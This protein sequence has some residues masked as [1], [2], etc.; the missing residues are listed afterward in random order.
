MP[1]TPPEPS[2]YGMQDCPE[3]QVLASPSQ[4]NSRQRLSK[5]LQSYPGAQSR[6]FVHGLP[7]VP[8]PVPVARHSTLRLVPS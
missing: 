6:M 1:V 3:G 5:G 7:S 8:V 2:A 4:Q